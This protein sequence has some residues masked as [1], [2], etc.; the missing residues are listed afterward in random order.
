MNR[1]RERDDGSNSEVGVLGER[2]YRGLVFVRR[3]DDAVPERSVI[4]YVKYTQSNYR[5]TKVF[6]RFDPIA[7]LQIIILIP[8]PLEL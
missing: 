7:P 2:L 4:R 3:L 6:A 5:H 1:G 8:S